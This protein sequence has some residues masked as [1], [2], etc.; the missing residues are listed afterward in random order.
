[1]GVLSEVGDHSEEV[2]IEL[3]RALAKKQDMVFAK[4]SDLQLSVAQSM[5]LRDHV[6]T[7]TNGLYRLKQALEVLCPA[8]KGIVLPPNIWRHVNKMEID[9]IVPPFIVQ[10]WCTANK[11]GNKK[12]INT[13]YYCSRP[14]Q[15]LE[16][17]LRRMFMDNTFQ[18][19]SEFSSLNNKIVI[20]IGFNKSDS[21]FLGTWRPCNRKKGNLSLF[22]QTF[23]CL[24][25]P[26]CEDYINE[27]ITI[28]KRSIQFDLQFRVLWMT[29]F[30]LL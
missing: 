9:G 11:K 25:G 10:V 28:G 17:M 30:I 18:D 7:G 13:F 20:S 21:N 4:K 14:S 27:L 12:A 23:A 8:L 22:V 2:V 1:M 29:I 24:E 5:V 3:L 15:L 19:S 16:N 6:G 26:V